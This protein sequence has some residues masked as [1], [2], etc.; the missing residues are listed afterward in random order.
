VLHV[1][2]RN[3][4]ATFVGDLATADHIPGS[5]FDCIIL[6]QTL[7]LVYELRPAVRTLHRI[8]KPGGVL[9]ATVPGIT[10]VAAGSEWGHTWHWSFTLN[11]LRRLLGEAFGEDALELETHGNVLAATAFLH[12]LAA[13]ELSAED[14]DQPDADYPVIITVRAGKMPES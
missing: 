12:G 6:T 14:L 13:D 1:H 10:P 8:L 5:A 3:P 11:S 2:D 7:Q 9:L 4:R